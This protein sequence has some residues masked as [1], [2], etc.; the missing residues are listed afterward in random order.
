METKPYAD[1]SRSYQSKASKMQVA[2]IY[3]FLLLD[4]HVAWISAT[5]KWQMRRAAS[6]WFLVGQH[7][8][9]RASRSLLGTTSIVIS[10]HID[11]DNDASRK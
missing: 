11:I 4:L 8:H 6:D 5:I 7:V 1:N 3:P 2:D 9:D 10:L